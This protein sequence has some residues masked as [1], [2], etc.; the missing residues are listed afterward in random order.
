M[1]FLWWIRNYLFY[2]CY[3]AAHGGWGGWN[4]WGTCSAS[5]GIGLR[6]R[7]RV[8]DSPEPSKGGH[9]CFGESSAYEICSDHQCKLIYMLVSVFCS[10]HVLHSN[11]NATNTSNQFKRE[12]QVSSCLN[13]HTCTLMGV[14]WFCYFMT[15]LRNFSAVLNE[16]YYRLRQ[17]Q[18]TRLRP[19]KCQIVYIVI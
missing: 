3:D 7:D 1:V 8:C 14:V 12:V 11:T 4:I 13:K 6:R 19:I 2:I 10:L 15:I 9:Q 16:K 17:I 18:E 5:C